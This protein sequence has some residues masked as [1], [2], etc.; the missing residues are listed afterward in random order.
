MGLGKRWG[1]PHKP[2]WVV[3]SWWGVAVVGLAHLECSQSQASREG[4]PELLET[5]PPGVEWPRLVTGLALWEG[6]RA[7]GTREA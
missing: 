6:Q 1:H 4:P 5:S 3:E 7:G 2:F